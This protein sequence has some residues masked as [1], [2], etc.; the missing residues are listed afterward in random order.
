MEGP[1]R[2][3]N[4]FVEP[5]PVQNLTPRLKQLFLRLQEKYTEQITRA[6]NDEDL[7]VKFK[8]FIDKRE[9]ISNELNELG[10]NIDNCD[11]LRDDVEKD[12]KKYDY[13]ITVLVDVIEEIYAKLDTYL[14][15][16]NSYLNKDGTV[17]EVYGKVVV[18]IKEDSIFSNFKE[19]LK[20]IVETLYE[21]YRGADCRTTNGGHRSLRKSR[22]SRRRSSR[23]A[24]HKSRRKSRK[25]RSKSRKIRRKNSKK[26]VRKSRR[27]VRKSRRTRRNRRNGRK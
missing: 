9:N 23:K 11:I 21:Q 18:F 22:I 5:V 26:T 13:E 4:Y 14:K 3:G 16:P 10:T 19:L 25:T 27:S 24:I 7:S 17:S 12:I 1:I 6:I 8:E 2:V 15:P 20:K